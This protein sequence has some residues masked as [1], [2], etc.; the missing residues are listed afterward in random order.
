MTEHALYFHIPFCRHRCAYCDFNTYAGQDALIPAYVEALCREIEIVGQAAPEEVEAS[1]IFFGGGT[2]SL[3]S[4]SDFSSIFKTLRQNFNLREDAEISLE[5]NPGTLTERYLEGLYAL[6]FNRLSLGVQS[7]HPDELRMLERNHSYGDVISA[8]LA[9]RKAGFDNLS[10][11]LIFGL[12]EQSLERWQATV[13]LILGLH[14]K[15]L[16]LYALTIEEGT[17]FGLWAERG[18]LPLPDPDLAAEMYEWASDYLYA[19]DYQQYEISNWTKPNQ[20]CQHN[21]QYWRN[22]PYLGFGAGGHGYA[23]G[24]RYANILGIQ[25]Y[26]DRLSQEKNQLSFPLSPAVV[27]KEIVG[28][29]QEMQE[30]LLMGLRLT[31]EGV[32]AEAFHTRFG[33]SL[34]NVFSKEIDELIGLG[35]LEWADKK[36]SEV[37]KTSEVLRLTPR[38][39]LLGN[40]VF[41]RFVS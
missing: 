5:A 31:N 8:A 37:S 41:L 26:I 11:D 28:S 36:T 24:M 7:A 15:H 39:R 6:G 33:R 35:L 3:L 30:H 23:T 12:P 27:S 9:A 17:P 38:G 14:P 2:P 13:K 21:L 34:E 18:M 19:K 22:L 4:V 1:T 40:Q 16:S 25:P 20:E 10:F 29:E 32:S